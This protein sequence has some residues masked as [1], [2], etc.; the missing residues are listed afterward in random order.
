MYSTV[1]SPQLAGKV[2]SLYYTLPIY[3]RTWYLSHG[4]VQH[5]QKDSIPRNGPQ[6]SCVRERSQNA[7]EKMDP[8][9]VTASILAVVARAVGLQNGLLSDVLALKSS[10]F[11]TGTSEEEELLRVL[12]EYAA[13]MYHLNALVS[14]PAISE[15]L[16]YRELARVNGF[17]KSSMALS[18]IL[19]KWFYAEP[20]AKSSK[21]RLKPL[22]SAAEQM[23][24]LLPHVQR[25]CEILEA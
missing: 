19:L 14:N 15:R 25:Q 9:S 7:Q 24:R 22:Q 1:T 5:R 13:S 3:S 17:A 10:T 23:R 6:A 8:L 16:G 18:T 21:Q 2:A 4:S 12:Q 11:L 20:H